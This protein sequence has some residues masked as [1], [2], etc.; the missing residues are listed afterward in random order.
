MFPRNRKVGKRRFQIHAKDSGNPGPGRTARKQRG[1]FAYTEIPISLELG[2]IATPR[3]VS[4]YRVT[5]SSLVPGGLR[6]ELEKARRILTHN[7]AKQHNAVRA[8]NV[9][10]NDQAEL[11]YQLVIGKNV[12]G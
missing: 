2:A 11:V 12:T 1:P 9:Q 7:S 3:E 6:D 5:P 10:G 4:N 8:H